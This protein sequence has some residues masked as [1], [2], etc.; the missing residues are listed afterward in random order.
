M[1]YFTFNVVP[2]YK[3][4]FVILFI[5]IATCTEN[6]KE[7]KKQGKSPISRHKK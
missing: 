4:I 7:N 1:N 3:N 6:G 2:R 5:Y